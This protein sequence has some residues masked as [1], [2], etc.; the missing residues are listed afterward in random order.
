[1][2]QTYMQLFSHPFEADAQFMALEILSYEYYTTKDTKRKEEVHLGIL[3]GLQD[4]SRQALLHGILQ[5]D[6]CRSPVQQK[7][8]LALYGGDSCDMKLVD[9]FLRP[10]SIE[11]YNKYGAVPLRF[12][13]DGNTNGIPLEQVSRA[14]MFSVGMTTSNGLKATYLEKFL[15][16]FYPSLR[17]NR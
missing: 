6:Y 12:I 8:V 4:I 11:G 15:D 10:M 2:D 16:E 3:Y 1:M 17:D 5:T 13:I 7:N 14:M 9:T